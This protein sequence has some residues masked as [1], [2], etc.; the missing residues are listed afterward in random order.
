MLKEMLDAVE[1]EWKKLTTEALY[2]GQTSEEAR[3]IA[4]AVVTDC[5][6]NRL[7]AAAANYQGGHYE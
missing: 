4:T 3:S 2:S 6:A 7:E 5:V 1:V